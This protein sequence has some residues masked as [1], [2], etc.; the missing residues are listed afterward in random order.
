[1][2]L[3]HA[4]VRGAM[5]KMEPMHACTRCPDHACGCVQEGLVLAGALEEH[6]AALEAR[7][8]SRKQHPLALWNSTAGR[9]S[10]VD[11]TAG[12]AALPRHAHAPRR[13]R[14]VCGTAHARRCRCCVALLFAASF[15][16]V[17]VSSVAPVADF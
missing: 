14:H 2:V 7:A 5:H 17:S 4:V 11:S 12:T 16:E 13:G 6:V 8:G 3:V 10:R 15:A 1:M 9:S